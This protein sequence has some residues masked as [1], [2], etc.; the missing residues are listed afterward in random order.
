MVRTGL[1]QQ[2]APV[3]VL[4]QPGREHAARRPAPHHDD[5]EVHSPHPDKMTK[6]QTLP[7]ARVQCRFGKPTLLQPIAI[8][9]APVPALPV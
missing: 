2:H 5:I 7:T 6:R 9:N 4:A 1:D 3:R 8:A